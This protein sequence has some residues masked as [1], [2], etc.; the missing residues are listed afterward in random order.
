MRKMLMR[1]L[2][3]LLLTLAHTLPAW[4]EETPSLDIGVLSPIA[5]PA[6]QE[7]ASI[8]MYCGPTQGSFRPEG[9]MLDTS[10]PYVYFGQYDCWSMVAVGTPEAMGAIGWVESALIPFPAEP[11]LSFDDALSIMVEDDTFLTV[12]P[13]AEA[14]EQLCTIARGTQVILL[15]QLGEWAYV[16]SL[17]EDMPVRAFLPVSAIL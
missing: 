6:A 1:A 16:Q 3:S 8:D 13:F 9:L 10:M 12:T 15:S 14:P 11:Q 4:A 5:C 17:I 2:V 7:A